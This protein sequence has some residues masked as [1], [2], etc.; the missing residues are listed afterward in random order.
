MSFS[1]LMQRGTLAAL[2]S[3]ATGQIFGGFAS[4]PS[5]I[6]VALSTAD[7]GETGGTIAEPSGNAYAR[8][9]TAPADW[10]DPTDADPSVV[11]NVNAITFATPTGAWGNVTHFAL[12]DASSGGN[13]IGSGALT[14]ARN[15]VTDD[16][17][18]FPAN[19]L[20]VSV[21]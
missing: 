16:V 15:I 7:P 19:S 2:F 8:A 5:N 21:D 11:D 12:F 13:L 14:A 1:Q 6:F 20:T 18:Q 17:V 10:S 9:S 3:K 4:A